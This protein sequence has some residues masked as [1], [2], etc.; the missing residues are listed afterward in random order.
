MHDNENNPS[1]QP[2][3][4]AEVNRIKVKK[5]TAK[6]RKKNAENQRNW[7]AKQRAAEALAIAN[8]TQGDIWRRNRQTLLSA[9]QAQD[10]Q[11]RELEFGQL[12]LSVA[13]VITHLP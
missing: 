10:L 1:V 7:Q 6:Q 13:D 5:T 3:P 12:A 9:E 8:L 11:N 2:D 4:L